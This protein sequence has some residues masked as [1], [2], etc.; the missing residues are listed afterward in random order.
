MPAPRIMWLCHPIHLHSFYSVVELV[1][2][3]PPSSSLFYKSKAGVR[4]C[5]ICQDI[6]VTANASGKAAPPPPPHCTCLTCGVSVH[7]VCLSRLHE[8][9]MSPYYREHRIDLPQCSG[10]RTKLLRK[11]PPSPPPS[12]STI[13]SLKLLEEL[14]LDPTL[15]PSP[16][17]RRLSL[18]DTN[19]SLALVYLQRYAPYVAGGI[20]LG[21]AA[22][23]GMPAVALTGLGVGLSGHKWRPKSTAATAAASPTD[24][25]WAR[26][27]CW[28]LKQSCPLTD[29]TYKQ[30]AALLRRYL[31]Q[32]DAAPTA[33]EIYHL[34]YHL[35]ASR[36]ELVGAVNSALC[37]AFRA[38]AKASPFVASV[39]SLVRD[40]QVYVGHALAVTMNTYPA[41]SVSELSV[42]Q[43]TEAVEK[44]VY[45]D[46]YSVVFAAFRR[47][48]A[49]HNLTLL[50]HVAEVQSHRVSPA[51]SP[52][53]AADVAASKRIALEVWLRPRW[54][55]DCVH[56]L[57]RMGSIEYPLGKLQAL[58]AAFRAIC[59]MAET[60]FASAPNADTLLPVVVDLLVDA[61]PRLEQFVAQLAFISTLTKGGGRGMEG[62]ALT[63]FHAALRALAAIEVEEMV[64]VP[65]TP[66]SETTTDDDDDEFFDAVQDTRIE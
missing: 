37:D 12:S 33:D 13:L 66:P 24:A 62:Y 51:F 59:E 58:A 20:L 47:D 42:V 55:L 61:A 48:F 2:S 18:D 32:A 44:I 11:T 1:P 49:R 46:I 16:R 54:L 35:F 22:L 53:L 43:T 19:N 52:A 21:G 34:L 7:R 39:P 9:Q 23:F 17:T 4:R 30:D 6:V 65:A 60:Q 5:A 26:R 56:A 14:S 50:T 63:T 40:A 31:N 10:D 25:D 29:A 15:P 28:E 38:R 45:S 27:I 3:P 8:Q 41:L 57:D 64:T 36:S